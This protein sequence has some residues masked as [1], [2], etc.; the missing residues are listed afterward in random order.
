MSKQCPGFAQSYCRS[1]QSH[2]WIGL[3]TCT[4]IQSCKLYLQVLFQRLYIHWG[5]EYLLILKVRNSDNKCILP[6]LFA[7]DGWSALI[8][9]GGSTTAAT[10]TRELSVIIIYGFQPRTVITK[11]STLDVTAVLDPPVIK[12]NPCSCRLL[13]SQQIFELRKVSERHKM[14]TLLLEI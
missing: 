2:L 9:R 3:E 5:N 1:F 10:S 6:P 13:S 14:S 7:L 4:K 11:C 12:S 8:N